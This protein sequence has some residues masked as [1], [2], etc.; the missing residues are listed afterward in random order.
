MNILDLLREEERPILDEAGRAVASLQ[1]YERDGEAATRA[2]LERLYG[3]VHDAIRTRDL[4][5]L[6]SA[7][8]EIAQQRFDAGFDLSEVLT[9]FHALETAIWQ[10]ALRRIPGPDLPEALGLMGTALAHGKDTLACAYVSLASKSK[11]P[12]LDLSALFKGTQGW[13]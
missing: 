8:T 9:A 13:G 3:L 5:P 12:T 6:H 4:T 2:R 7:V 10:R 11:T 1:H